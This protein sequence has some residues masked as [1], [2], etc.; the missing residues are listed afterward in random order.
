MLC[1]KYFSTQTFSIDYYSK[2][3]VPYTRLF[4]HLITTSSIRD[5]ARDFSVS[6]DVIVNKLSRLSRNCIASLERLRR[7]VKLSEH[8]VADGF[9]SYTVS[10]FFP[11]HINLLAGSATQLVYWFDYV[12]LRRKGRMTPKQREKRNELEQVFRADPK[13]IERSFRLLYDDI[14]HLICD[15]R[16]LSVVLATDEH[17]AYQRAL[18]DHISLNGLMQQYRFRKVSVS[19]KR[20]RNHTNPLFAVNYIDRQIRKDM[21]EHVRETVCFGRNVNCALDRMVVYLTYHNLKKPYRE[22][23]GDLRS[24]AEVAGLNRR[25]VRS[26]C[27]GMFKRRAIFSLVK[28]EGRYRK[29]WMRDYV[30]PLK[31]APE[32]RPKHIAA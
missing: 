27:Y 17:P 11:C 29:M 5:M 26:I 28:P 21:A 24:H 12:T 18:T 6:P 2:R 16:Q 31:E 3:T 22:V 32:F 23:K 7:E 30:T 15:G 4:N 14:S 8:L 13:G 20:E 25:T 9:E 1:G 10:Q 19:S